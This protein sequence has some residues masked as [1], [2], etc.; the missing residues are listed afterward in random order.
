MTEADFDLINEQGAR[1][2]ALSREVARL[3]K[4]LKEEQ[5][6]RLRVQREGGRDHELIYDMRALVN[7]A[8]NIMATPGA[9]GLLKDE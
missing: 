6:L 3:E 4:A 2:M 7:A 8:R 1:I 5:A 9:E